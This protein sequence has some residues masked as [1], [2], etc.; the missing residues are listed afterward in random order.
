MYQQGAR[1]LM[2]TVKAVCNG[3]TAKF[4]MEYLNNMKGNIYKRSK[5][6]KMQDYL[7]IEVVEDALATRSAMM[8]GFTMEEMAKKRHL[9]KTVLQNEIFA[10]DIQVFTQFHFQYLGFIFFKKQIYE[11]KFKCRSVVKNLENMLV[12]FGLERLYDNPSALFESGYFKNGH[13]RMLVDAYK[14]Q[15]SVVREQAIPLVETGGFNPI[16]NVGN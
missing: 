1:F 13:L 16:S 5:A 12:C 2:K 4:P 11:Q 14:H 8:V 9:S 7:E 3:A 15:V 6:K 10:Q